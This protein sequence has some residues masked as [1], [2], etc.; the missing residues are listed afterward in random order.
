M[1]CMQRERETKQTQTREGQHPY[2]ISSSW[3]FFQ[4][5]NVYLSIQE[6]LCGTTQLQSSRSS[7][8]SIQ[9]RGGV[10]ISYVNLFKSFRLK[11]TDESMPPEL[12]DIYPQRNR[13]FS[14][15]SNQSQCVDESNT[16]VTVAFFPF[17]P[18]W[19]LTHRE[20][21]RRTLST[22][23]KQLVLFIFQFG[24]ENK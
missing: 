12:T 14:I 21:R 19:P 18:T 7:S 20:K 22:I 13:H 10:V 3:V 6:K 9:P 23:D 11:D 24:I 4:L 2:M 17:N 16:F 15:P 1:M 5:L 8:R